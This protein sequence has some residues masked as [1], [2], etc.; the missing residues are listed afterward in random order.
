MKTISFIL[1]AY[2]EENAIKHT[3]TSIAE[4]C[5]AKQY[6][7]EIIIID[8]GSTDGTYRLAGEIT[9]KNASVKALRHTSNRGKGAAVRTGMA[10]AQGDILLFLDADGSTNVS[11][12][13]SF[14][15]YLK[16]N[17]D[18]VIGSRYLPESTIGKKQ[19]HL[20]VVIG[21][22]GNLLIQLLLLPG[23]AD[24]QCGC[25]VFSRKAAQ[26]IFSR[27]TID[28]WGF[29]MEILAIARLQGLQVK[30]VP[31]S[32]FDATNRASRFRPM[33][34]MLRTLAELCSIKTNMLFGRYTVDER[35]FF[36]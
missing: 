2:N 36:F 23:V 27:Q 13:D 20:R 17:Y 31:I 32:W 10:A 22:I 8:D 25:K 18:V 1:P 21:R 33:K 7:Y 12:L 4:Y 30:E 6:P 15:P 3:V 19:P 11:E 35:K 28:G 26:Q 5:D 14:F 24:T 9:G 29:D 16:E 34:D